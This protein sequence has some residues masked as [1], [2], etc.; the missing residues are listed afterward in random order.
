MR[1]GPQVGAGE[2]AE[3]G[4]LGGVD[5]GRRGPVAVAAPGLD[6][7]EHQQPRAPRR[8]R[9]SRPSGSAS[10]GPRSA[11][12]RRSAGHRRALRRAA[13]VRR[14]RRG[15]WWAWPH[16]SRRQPRDWTTPPRM[17]KTLGRSREARARGLER[18]GRTR[19]VENTRPA[20]GVDERGRVGRRGG[21]GG[22]LVGLSVWQAPGCVAPPLGCTTSRAS[23][24]GGGRLGAGSATGRSRDSGPGRAAGT[25]GYGGPEGGSGPGAGGVEVWRRGSRNARGQRTRGRPGGRKASGEYRTGAPGR[26]RGRGAGGRTHETR[27]AATL[28]LWRTRERC[29]PAG[30][31]SSTSAGPGCA[32]PGTRS[33]TWWC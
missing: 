21:A 30:I 12:R 13:P 5:G 11:A 16:P 2:P 24:A 29:R 22:G 23:G 27:A 3:L 14:D 8:P 25:G 15:A 9:R 10:C 31:C 26:A 19:S 6:L 32:S 4:L 20:A 1:G 18:A 7:A 28:G 17:W 33:G